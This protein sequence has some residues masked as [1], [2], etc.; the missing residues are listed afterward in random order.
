MPKKVIIF[1]GTGDPIT[2]ANAI[3]DATI[4]GYAEWKVMGLLNDSLKIGANLEGYEILGDLNDTQKFI[5]LG[6]YFINAILRIDGNPYRIKKIEELSI[7]LDRMVTFIHPTAYVSPGVQF[8]PGCA[9][10][11]NAC[12]NSGTIFGKGCLILQ[13]ATVGHNCTL[14]D[15]CHISAQACLGAELKIGRGVHFGMNS[16]VRENITIGDFSTIGMGSV[17]LKDIGVAEIWAGSPAR[18]LRK[19][20]D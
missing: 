9:V 4:R 19:A 8:G 2:I 7:P 10:M 3:T 15:Y 5:E 1:G 14:S 6:Y 18:F 11:P 17:L 13:G 20:K 12:I 16:C